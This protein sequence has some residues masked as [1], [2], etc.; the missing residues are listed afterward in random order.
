MSAL[1]MGSLFP[2]ELVTEMFSKVK[3]HSS[4]AKMAPS[5]PVPFTGKDYFT[6]QFDSDVSIVGENGAKP[7]G[8][9]S[10][11]PVTVKPLKVVY[12]SRVSDEFMTAAEDYRLNVL[13][14]FAAAFAKKMGAALDK[15]AIHG[16]NP[17]TGL[18]ATA[19]I[20]NNY[21]DYV[22]ADTAITYSGSAPD[23]NLESA[24]KVLEDNEYAPNGIAM[25]P[26]MR[27]AMG[28]MVNN[29]NGAKYPGFQFGGVS[30]LNGIKVDSNIT[31]GSA[32]KSNDRALVGD[33]NA[34]RW[35]YAKQ[36]PLEVIEY[37]NPDNSE[38]GDL[39]G[40]NQV[41]LRSE[42]WIGWG[43]LD[44]NAFCLVCKDGTPIITT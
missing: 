6:F 18:P 8:D 15:M 7:A 9:A 36:I 19:T 1:S 12:Q 40:H 28:A 20:G 39:K 33:F 24:I 35:G 2:K 42:A 10:I 26:I 3:G 38:A 25:A 21:F 32:S 44:K 13:K 14:E 11:D 27:G 5:E 30:D 41:L 17:A 23:D 29:A 37:G 34:F 43:I 4:L 31:V 22:C 16:I